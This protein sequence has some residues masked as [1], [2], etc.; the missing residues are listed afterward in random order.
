MVRRIVSGGQTGADRAALDFA[1]EHAIPYGGWAPRGRRA[2]DGSIPAAY[3]LAEMATASYRK[4]TERNVLDSD[5]TAIITHGT[6]RGG[7]ALTIRL[8]EAGRRP[9]LHL[10]LDEIDIEQ[11]AERLRAWI[12]EH[13]I[14]ILN[15]AGPRASEDGRIYE[16]TKGLLEQALAGHKA[17]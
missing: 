7:S 4:R 13:R 2:E 3:R 1:I 17:R 6:P 5:G 10:D 11:A 15:I 9:F 12:V 16:A 8:A 14:S